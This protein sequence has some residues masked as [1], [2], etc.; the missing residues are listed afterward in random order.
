MQQFFKN[1][2]I[3]KNA[4]M[5]LLFVVVTLMI[6]YPTLRAEPLWDDWVFIFNSHTMKNVRPIEFWLWGDYR[7]S[8]PVFYTTLSAM[9][10]NWGNDVYKYHLT[11]VLLHASNS[12]L[13]FKILKK[14]NG[15][16]AFFLSLIYLIHPLQFFSVAW[17]VQL[18]TLMAIF[19]F[20][21]ALSFFIK[22]V[23]NSSRAAYLLSILFFALSL[24]SKSVFMPI[25]LIMFFFKDRIRM[26][27]FMLLCVYSLTITMWST[28][29]KNYIR[30]T[31][32]PSFLVSNVIA[33]EQVFKDVTKTDSEEKTKRYPLD[34]V[35]L[36]FNNFNKYILFIIYPWE[37][38]LV[39]QT[40]SVTYS[41]YEMLSTSIVLCLIAFLFLKLKD[42]DDWISIYSLFFFLITIV[43]LCGLIFIPI[44]QYSNFVHYWLSVPLLGVILF[45]SMR[46]PSRYLTTSLIS[47]IIFYGFTTVTI[48][49]E[50]NNPVTMITKSAEKSPENQLIPLIL[51]KH[52]FFKKEYIKSNAI[53]LK[54]KKIIKSEDLINR[55]IEINLKGMNGEK[56]ND[57]TL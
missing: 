6:Y 14:L 48:A 52:Y 29:I 31:H 33:Q 9:I 35:V 15:N 28:H 50:Q 34:E 53:L 54:V 24:F 40:T 36:T 22:N 17:I 43:P 26:V 16:N 38:L 10:K 27:P 13:V 12:F 37:V 56:I 32:I 25:G 44:F 4:L 19:F 21:I 49:R 7:R 1:N 23:K 42:W 47:L 55:D 45:V 18:K 3:L 30:T 46:K 11:S 5:M 51:A 39:N 2:S 20:L 8:W 57:A 41:F